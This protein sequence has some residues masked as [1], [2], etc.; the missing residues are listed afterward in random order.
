MVGSQQANIS[1]YIAEGDA[2]TEDPKWSLT[3]ESPVWNLGY[4]EIPERG[5]FKVVLAGNIPEGAVDSVALD[6]L[7]LVEGACSVPEEDNQCN[8][9]TDWCHYQNTNDPQ[10]DQLDW[11]LHTRWDPPLDGLPEHNG[12]TY[13]TH[14]QMAIQEESARLVSP[15]F[16]FNATKK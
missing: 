14:A 10:I 9:D 11:V 2:I 15:N 3:H 1:V 16:N 7:N 12:F 13:M 8:F 5:S 6:D 4:L